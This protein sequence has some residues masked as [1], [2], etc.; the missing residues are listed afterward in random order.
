VNNLTVSKDADS[1]VRT[2]VAMADALA[3]DVVAEGIET[4]E[5]MEILLALTCTKAQGYFFCRPVDASLIPETVAE[6][7]NRDTWLN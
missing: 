4:A 5:Q 3:A 6:L 1:L 7:Q 2:I